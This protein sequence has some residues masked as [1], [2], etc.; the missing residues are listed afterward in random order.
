MPERCR[1][2]QDGWTPLHLAAD[3]GGSAV[4]EQ[5]LTAGAAVDAQDEV[6]RGGGG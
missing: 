2:R 4:V 3:N 6:K 5:L 1:A